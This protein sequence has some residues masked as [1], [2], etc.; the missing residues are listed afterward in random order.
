MLGDTPALGHATVSIGGETMS[1]AV[2]LSRHV[3]RVEG[4]D[5]PDQLSLVNTTGKPLSLCVDRPVV[6]MG[7]GVDYS[8]DLGRIYDRIEALMSDDRAITA[9]DEAER[10]ERLQRRLWSMVKAVDDQEWNSSFRLGGPSA[11]PDSDD[12]QAGSAEIVLCR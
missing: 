3:L 2:A 6:V 10:H 8:H 5:A 12:C 4:S 7:N 1:L 9:D 11:P